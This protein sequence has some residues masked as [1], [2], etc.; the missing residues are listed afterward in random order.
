M[1][2]AI[3]LWCKRHEPED[4]IEDQEED[5]DD[6]AEDYEDDVERPADPPPRGPHPVWL[7]EMCKMLRTPCWERRGK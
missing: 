4:D 7:C 6:R 2:K 3:D 1:V 5:S